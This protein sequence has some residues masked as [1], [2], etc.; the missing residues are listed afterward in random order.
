MSTFPKISSIDFHTILLENHL[1]QGPVP[2]PSYPFQFTANF[3]Y[4]KPNKFD[5][6]FLNPPH[7]GMA[8]MRNNLAS[9]CWESLK[10]K[11]RYIMAATHGWK[12][13]SEEHPLPTTIPTK[14]LSE[15][16]IIHPP[17]PPFQQLSHNFLLLP[18]TPEVIGKRLAMW[19]NNSRQLAAWICKAQLQSAIT[20]N[21]SWTWPTSPSSDH[22]ICN[23]D[24]T[25]SDRV[26]EA[27]SEDKPSS[28][29]TS[30]SNVSSPAARVARAFNSI[31]DHEDLKRSR[32]SSPEDS[33][34]D[35]LEANKK[36][37]VL[38]QPTTAQRI[39]ERRALECGKVE[40]YCATS[41]SAPPPRPVFNAR[42]FHTTLS[43]TPAPTRDPRLQLSRAMTVPLGAGF[44]YNSK[45]TEFTKYE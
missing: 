40:S 35:G 10:R 25:A 4:Y 2:A 13:D 41:S 29:H 33:V 18:E 27:S 36:Q 11:T 17:F 39:E 24:T 15:I 23:R 30:F 32:D 14:K 9:A 22:S 44:V 31:A 19:Q 3:D 34:C 5:F 6:C 26:T 38:W 43:T 7:E 16:G 42:S 1:V 21:C 8:V 20:P 28:M 37:V 12:G 45:V